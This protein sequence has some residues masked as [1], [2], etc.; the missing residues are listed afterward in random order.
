MTHRDGH[1]LDRRRFLRAAGGALAAS[2]APWKA[3]E[4]LR[5]A[6][7]RWEGYDTAIVVDALGGLEAPPGQWGELTP[8]VLTE[9]RRSGVTAVNVTI[10]PVGAGDD[11]FERAA[12]DVDRWRDRM[13]RHSARLKQ[14]R[15]AADI[16]AAKADGRLGVIFG[17]QD[18]AMLEGRLDR[19]GLFHDA[20]V[21]VIQ[22]TYNRRNEL[23]DGSLEAENHGLTDF[24]HDVVARMNELGLLVDLSHCGQRTTAEAIRA[25][26]GPVAITHSGCAALSALPRNKT[27]ADLRSLADRGGV[28]GIYFMPFLK[29]IGQSHA[30]DVV[31]HLEHAIDTCGEDHV[32][33]GTDG[34]IMPVELNEA[35]RAR[36]RAEIAT[37]RAAGISAPGETDDI[38][39]LIPDLNDARRLERLADLLSVRGHSD[40]RIEKVLGGNFLRLMREVWGG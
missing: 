9:L 32:G 5:I 23:G 21:R 38:V 2:V 16:V 24:G 25:S 40:A 15:T 1:S 14:I 36:I 18:A 29:E 35:Y 26:Q 31:R 30:E 7:R 33:V 13:A 3:P 27:D 4:A 20:G 10:G 39:P 19:L 6:V 17:F 12:S 22:L 8:A 34:S 11:L 28:A 37:R